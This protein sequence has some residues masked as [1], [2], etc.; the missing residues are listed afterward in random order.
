MVLSYCSVN[1]HLGSYTCTFHLENA[2]RGDTLDRQ[3]EGNNRVATQWPMQDCENALSIS[4]MVSP[5]LT[6][7]PNPECLVQKP[8]K[9]GQ[10][11]VSGD[12][13]DLT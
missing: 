12:F 6:K 13:P 11:V 9:K 7:E 10:L 2:A 8:N 5:R 3:K 1:V 4:S